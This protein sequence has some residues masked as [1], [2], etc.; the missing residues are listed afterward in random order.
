MYIEGHPFKIV[1]DHASLRWLMSQPDLRGRLAR[2][3]IKLQGFVFDIEL[4]M[5]VIM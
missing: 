3:A 1:T 4:A 2:W 5:G